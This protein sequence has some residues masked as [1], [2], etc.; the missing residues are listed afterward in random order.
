M[1]RS[2]GEGKFCTSP[3]FLCLDRGD[4]P[5]NK[6]RI[7][8][9][10]KNCGW[11]TSVIVEWADLRPRRCMNKKCNTSFLKYPDQLVVQMPEEVKAVEPEEFSKNKKTGKKKK[12]DSDVASN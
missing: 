5:M 1:L 6:G 8:Y 11:E 3:S 7:K 2:L 10:C 12:E 4:N 9:T